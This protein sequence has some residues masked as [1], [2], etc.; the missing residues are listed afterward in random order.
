MNTSEPK[1]TQIYILCRDRLNYAREAIRSAVEQDI[2]DVE[3][4]VSDNSDDDAVGEMIAAE[5]PGVTYI[6][7][8]PVLNALSHF[9]TVI[10][11]SGAEY[12][13]LFHDDDVLDPGYVRTMR[14]A[15]DA[16]PDIV[17]VGCNA[18]VLRDTTPTNHLFMMALA[19]NVVLTTAE[20]LLD[21]YLRFNKHR[22][23]PFP[24][25][26]YRQ[27]AIEGLYLDSRD[28][29]KH[30][31]VTFLMKLIER[32]NFL[33]L[34]KPL[35]QYRMHST[36]DSAVEH[37]GQRLRLLRYIYRHTSIGPQSEAVQEFRFRYWARWWRLARKHGDARLHRWRRRIVFA[38]LWRQVLRFAFSKP[39][40][41]LR[42]ASGAR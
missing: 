22:A 35:M 19:H 28:G 37:V 1:R 36:N 4:I 42:I 23:A 39:G 7:R 21:F 14:A 11:E 26:M 17:A 13:V 31:D 27:T 18:K 24:G 8:S 32:G 16:Q 15:L 40:F 2:D 29:G 3:I 25:Y 20:Q 41:W 6:R 9:R 10:E 33:W 38:Y 5:F 34:A 30:A 12:V